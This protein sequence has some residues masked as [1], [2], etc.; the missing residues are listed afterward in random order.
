MREF[1]VDLREDIP[2]SFWSNL[3][4]DGRS[5]PTTTVLTPC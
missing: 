2:Y 4:G 1:A 5:S 3:T